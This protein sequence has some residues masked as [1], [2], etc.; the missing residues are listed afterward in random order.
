MA[1]PSSA[2]PNTATE[3]V[4]KVPLIEVAFK[5]GMWRAP[6]LDLSQALRSKYLANETDI[7]YTWDWGNSRKGSWKPEDEETTIN[8]YL[9]D[10]EAG[11]QRNIDNNRHRTM[12]V[13]WVN[14]SSITARWTGQI[15]ERERSAKRERSEQS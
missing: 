2:D 5:N 15:P 13:V 8:R 7:G 14:P 9:I 3:H 12:R 1:A 4:E 6:P 10:F 11:I